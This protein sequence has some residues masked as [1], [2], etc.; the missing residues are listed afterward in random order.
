M[1]RYFSGLAVHKIPPH[2]S[3]NSC[4]VFSPASRTNRLFAVRPPLLFIKQSLSAKWESFCARLKSVFYNILQFQKKCSFN[5]LTSLT[6][7][8]EAVCVFKVFL[9]GMSCSHLRM[10]KSLLRDY[11]GF[12]ILGTNEW[13]ICLLCSRNSRFL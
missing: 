2:V 4:R 1:F 12:S 13:F 11:V 7:W 6:P 10:R 9:P 3:I 8:D 5:A